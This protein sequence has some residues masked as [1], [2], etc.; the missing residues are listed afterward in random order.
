LVG[1]IAYLNRDKFSFFKQQEDAK[2]KDL[3][4]KPYDSFDVVN[5]TQEE[6]LEI[7]TSQTDQFA[8]D[9]RAIVDS[10]PTVN[11]SAY[12]VSLGKV[13]SSP[14]ELKGTLE[15]MQTTGDYSLW[16][17]KCLDMYEAAAF[18]ASDILV[19]WA[20]APKQTTCMKTTFVDNVTETTTAVTVVT[21]KQK[22]AFLGVCKT[23]T[24][25]KETTERNEVAHCFVPHCTQEGI[26]PTALAVG[27]KIVTS[28]V[29]LAFA[30][31]K[32]A[33]QSEPDVTDYVNTYRAL[34]AKAA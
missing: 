5:M 9:V 13:A 1:I 22:K 32:A 34:N 24:S 26:D 20:K 6:V 2:P 25:T 3:D 7:C 4:N 15:L 8:N 16:V 27:N 29:E 17:S 11:M 12:L 14:A 18:K 28:A 21:N 10:V 23:N 19:E 30:G 33:Y 31:Y